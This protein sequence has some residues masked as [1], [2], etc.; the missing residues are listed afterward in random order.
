MIGRNESDAVKLGRQEMILFGRLTDNVER[1]AAANEELISLAKEERETTPGG[2]A[3]C[4]NCGRD[5]P[6]VHVGTMA[7]KGPLGEF[8][9]AVTCD[10]CEARFFAAPLGWYVTDNIDDFGGAE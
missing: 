1:L 10:H 6:I 8:V 3:V 9:I 5:N 7:D 2:P 4:P